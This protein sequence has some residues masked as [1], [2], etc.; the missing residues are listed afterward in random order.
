[1]YYK[2]TVCIKYY[3]IGVT[4]LTSE[5]VFNTFIYSFVYLLDV[6]PNGLTYSYS[7]KYTH[8]THMFAE[9][10]YYYF[11]QVIIFVY[12]IFLQNLYKSS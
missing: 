3:T 12:K 8:P 6:F 2:S 5:L 11:I 1:M 9:I 7:R 4:G 10:Y